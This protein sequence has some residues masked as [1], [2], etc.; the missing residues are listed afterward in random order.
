VALEPS[1]LQDFQVF[2]PLGSGATSHVVEAVQTATGRRVAIKMLAPPEEDLADELRERFA[3]EALVLAGLSSRYVGRILGFGFELGVPFLV[4]E[5]LVGETIDVWLKREGVLSLHEFS[6]LVSQILMGMR[7]CHAIR[8]VHRDI[9]P[10]NIFLQAAG[11]GNDRTAKLIDFGLARARGQGSLTSTSHVLGSVGYMAPEQFADAKNVGPSGDIYAAGCVIFR[12]LSGRLPFNGRQLEVVVQLKSERDP[13]ALSSFEDCPNIP[14][15]DAFLLKAMARKPE[16]RFI[17]AKEMLDAWWQIEPI[18]SQASNQRLRSAPPE[19]RTDETAA[20]PPTRARLDSVQ[21]R[22]EDDGEAVNDQDIDSGWNDDDGPDTTQGLNNKRF[23]T[24]QG[25][26]RSGVPL[27]P[28]SATSQTAI[29]NYV[30]QAPDEW[31]DMPTLR[32][33]RTLRELVANEREL[34][35]KKT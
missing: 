18:L 20:A 6:P 10:G 1:R 22:F 5:H 27:A 35:K 25:A 29:A 26:P 24:I 9:K 30:S 8:V 28:L 31:E 14:E 32:H 7:D 13:P 21:V 2:G 19:F 3:R 23:D 16:F 17:S 4:L 34:A 33:D 12:C 11:A 15:L